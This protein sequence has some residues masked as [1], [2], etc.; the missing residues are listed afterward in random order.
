MVSLVQQGGVVA[1]AFGFLRRFDIP[2]SCLIL[3]SSR[4]II[5]FLLMT[6]MEWLDCDTRLE[7]DEAVRW[8]PEL[9]QK[10]SRM[11]DFLHVHPG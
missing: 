1:F 4:L 3:P 10:E 9:V 2:T 6:A 7:Y 5:C 8:A 11:Q